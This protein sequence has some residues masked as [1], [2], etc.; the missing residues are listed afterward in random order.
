MVSAN[1]A[2]TLPE[3]DLYMEAQNTRA[4]KGILEAC[5][6]SFYSVYEI[7]LKLPQIF[8]MIGITKWATLFL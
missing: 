8:P 5:S 6:D 1:L 4:I 2:S 3:A 7:P